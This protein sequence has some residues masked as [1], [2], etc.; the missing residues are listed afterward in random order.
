MIKST[1]TD[2]IKW[3]NITDLDEG[4]SWFLKKVIGSCFPNFKPSLVGFYIV[5]LKFS[6]RREMRDGDVCGC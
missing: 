4:L 1:E 6:T 3:Y 5:L 2:H